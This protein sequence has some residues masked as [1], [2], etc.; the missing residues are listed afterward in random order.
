LRRGVALPRRL[1]PFLPLQIPDRMEDPDAW[2]GPMD[3]HGQR[4]VLALYIW[5]DEL[6]DGFLTSFFAR[7]TRVNPFFSNEK[8]GR[9]SA[10]R[11]A[12][13]GNN[14]RKSRTSQFARGA[15]TKHDWQLP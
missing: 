5:T 12:T 6:T 8:P 7:L 10:P 1:A 3:H 13:L 2:R 11:A 15:S 9:H 14:F 4:A